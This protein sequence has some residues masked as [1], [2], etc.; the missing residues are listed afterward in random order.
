MNTDARTDELEGLCEA[1]LAVGDGEACRRFLEDLCTPAELRSL[2]VRWRVARLL[3]RGVPYRKIYQLT[4]VSTATVARVARALSHGSG[5][6]QQ[7]LGRL[8][9]ER[10]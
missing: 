4:G 1:L 2:A 9:E 10:P 7:Q 6:Y 5:G 3:H 8:A